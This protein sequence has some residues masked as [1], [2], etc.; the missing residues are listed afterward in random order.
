MKSFTQKPFI[1]LKLPALLE[2]PWTD[3]IHD[4]ITGL[5]GSNGFNSILMVIDGL[6]N[7][8]HFVPFRVSHDGQEASKIDFET[9]VKASQYTK[10][11]HFRPRKHI[12]LTFQNRYL[13]APWSLITPVDS[14]SPQNW[15]AS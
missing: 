9:C 4:L 2:E 3:I 12:H 5:L 10:D 8:A 13:K 6:K 14:V 11:H 7:M 1:T 15:W